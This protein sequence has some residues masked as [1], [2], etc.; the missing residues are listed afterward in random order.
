MFGRS[1][2]ITTNIWRL[3]FVWFIYITAVPTHRRTKTLSI[4]KSDQKMLYIDINGICEN[5]KE[6][7]SILCGKSIEF[8][9]C[10]SRWYTYISPSNTRWKAPV[11]APSWF[12]S[13][14]VTGVNPKPCSPTA[15]GMLVRRRNTEIKQRIRKKWIICKSVKI[16][17]QIRRNIC[18]Q[19]RRK[20]REAFL[21]IHPTIFLLMLLTLQRM[22]I[23]MNLRSFFWTSKHYQ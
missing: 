14:D 16:K 13:Q 22:R 15:N 18:K 5:H 4:M 23:A 20:N 3:T 6:H 12:N 2:L 9:L 7:I 1:Y 11:L 17:T 21:T 8:H 19:T 10:Y